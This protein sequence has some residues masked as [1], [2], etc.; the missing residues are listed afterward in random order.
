MI[1]DILKSGKHDYYYWMKAKQNKSNVYKNI[2]ISFFKNSGQK[3]LYS[4]YRSS[5][6]KLRIYP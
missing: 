2:L 1:I 4:I 5:K 6:K 3:D